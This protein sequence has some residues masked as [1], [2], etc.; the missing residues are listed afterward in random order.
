M[1]DEATEVHFEN[2]ATLLGLLMGHQTVVADGM[3]HGA[4]A[5]CLDELDAV[6]AAVGTP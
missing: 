5:R 3:V 6:R 2:L 1:I 4:I